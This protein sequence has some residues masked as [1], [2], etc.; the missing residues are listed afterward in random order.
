MVQ[1]PIGRILGNP[2]QQRAGNKRGDAGAGPGGAEH[3]GAAILSCQNAAVK[4]R[5]GGLITWLAVETSNS[6]LQTQGKLN[7]QI[8][9]N[10]QWFG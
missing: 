8:R 7:L 2:H 3:A 1:Q 9:T 6:K 4:G 5:R 10:V